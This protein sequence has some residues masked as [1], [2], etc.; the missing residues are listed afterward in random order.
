MSAPHPSK[1]LRA[2]VDVFKYRDYRQ[3]LAAFYAHKKASGLSYRAFS[4]AAGLGAPNYLKLVI[5]GKRN[6]SAEMAERFARTCHLGPEGT[7]YFR[8]L[9]A[10]NQATSDDERNL[11]H[12]Q[13]TKFARFRAAQRLDVAQSEYHANWYISAVRE[14]LAC[15][16]FREDPE[17]LA[18]IMDPPI[19]AAEASHALEVLKSLGMVERDERGRLV[20]ATRAVSTGPQASGLN[21]RNYHS[22]MMQRAVLAMQLIPAEQR[23]I[24]GLTLSGSEETL[25]EVKRRVI[26]FRAELVALCDADPAPTRVAQLNMQFFPLTRHLAQ[27]TLTPDSSPPTQTSKPTSTPESTP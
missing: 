9:V 11:L 16:D 13:L 15:P 23:Y 1:R 4:R 6:L 3:F 24:S 12:E 10:F 21:I 7:D 19:S 2:P 20:Q 27:A 17:W 5:D 8:I 25:A 22:Q 18:A 26:E 14:L